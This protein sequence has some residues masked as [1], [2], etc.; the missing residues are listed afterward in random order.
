M[1]HTDNPKRIGCDACG[2]DFSR[3]HDV[4]R[5]KASAC[6]ALPRTRGTRPDTSVGRHHGRPTYQAV[7]PP[8][9]EVEARSRGGSQEEASPKGWT[10]WDPEQ[11]LS[12]SSC[13]SRIG[14]FGRLFDGGQGETTDSGDYWG[15]STA[16]SVESE[17]ASASWVDVP[18]HAMDW[19][20]CTQYLPHGPSNAFQG[21]P[22]VDTAAVNTPALNLDFMVWE[23]QWPFAYPSS[24]AMQGSRDQ[25]ARS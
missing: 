15:T 1:E 16:T 22:A 20:G 3:R 7:E 11:H 8:R 18:D 24:H 21:T 2:A 4:T 13:S 25:N 23:K 5:H 10:D 9:E 6:P 12:P 17:A 19:L 14:V